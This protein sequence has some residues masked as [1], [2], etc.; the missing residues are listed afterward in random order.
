MRLLELAQVPKAFVHEFTSLEKFKVFNTNNIWVKVDAIRRLVTE[1]AL[2]QMELIENAKKLPDGRQVI[3]LER[4]M[5]SAIRFFQGAHGIEVPRSRFLPV[6]KT[7]DLLL[8]Q[9]NLYELYKGKL[10]MSNKRKLPSTPLV[11]LDAVHFGTVKDFN[12]RF[13]SIP[14]ILELSHF[15]VSGDVS[16][17]FGV[18]LRGTVIIVAHPGTRIDVPSGSTM[19]SAVVSGNLKVLSI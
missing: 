11:K 6:K 3:Q 9:S 13:A 8:I 14:D 5:G 10:S 7:D 18:S 12:A 17:G 4:A 19:Q 1:K 16:F 2:S 15:T